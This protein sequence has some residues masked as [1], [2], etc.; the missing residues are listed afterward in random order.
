M[1]LKQV[2]QH[3]LLFLIELVSQC[4][5]SDIAKEITSFQVILGKL[6]EIITD[7]NLMLFLFGEE[8]PHSCS[9]A[10]SVL[11]QMMLECKY[12]VNTVYTL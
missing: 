6:F 4:Y 11:L 9:S 3:C 12:S 5:L 8:D 7:K 1:K 2:Q 10:R